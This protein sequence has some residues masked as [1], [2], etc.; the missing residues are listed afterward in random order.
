[1]GQVG[2][3]T[4]CP[5]TSLCPSPENSH[6]RATAL[7]PTPGSKEIC[8]FSPTPHSTR[9]G[10]GEGGEGLDI[11][12]SFVSFS[13]WEKHS[14]QAYCFISGSLTWFPLPPTPKT[15]RASPQGLEASSPEGG[16]KIKVPSSHI[17]PLGAGPLTGSSLDV[18]FRGPGLEDFL[19]GKWE[20]LPAKACRNVCTPRKR[21]CIGW[22]MESENLV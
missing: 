12:G 11:G 22:G 15:I 6:Q 9:G 20:Y 7:R 21:V 10:G 5:C 3:Q 16:G 19:A 2:R 13:F 18:G 1:M 14:G 4:A 8:K 17:H